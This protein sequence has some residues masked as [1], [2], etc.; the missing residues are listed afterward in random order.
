[1]FCWVIGWIANHNPELLEA[2]RPAL[3]AMI[4]LCHQTRMMRDLVNFPFPAFMQW[5]L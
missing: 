1:M 2:L 4:Y 3:V 5:L